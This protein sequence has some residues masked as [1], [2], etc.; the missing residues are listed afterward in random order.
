MQY[1]NPTKVPLSLAVFLAT[2]HYDHIPDTI[3]AT[4]L[5]KP[6]R[7]TV[8]SKR[9]P[10]EDAFV[11]ILGVVKSRMGT[12]IHDGIEKAWNG[13]YKTAM[14]GLGYPDK[15]IERIK[16]NPNPDDVTDNDI[17]VYMEQ[18]HFKTVR[19]VQVSGKYDF[20]AAGVL[21]DFKSTGT[22]TWVNGTKTED[23]QL[24]G[25]IYRWLSPHIITADH[26]TIQFIFTDW[27]PGRAVSPDYP[28]RA[29]EALHIPLLTLEETEAFIVNKLEQI[30]Q[31]ANASE[32][33][34]PFCNDKELWRKDPVFKYY[35]NPQKMVRSTKNFTTGPEAYARQATD[36]GKG[37]V[38]EVPGQVIA[39]K[40]C[41]AF[42]ICSQK[43]G[44]IADGSLIIE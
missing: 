23:Y 40:Y 17:P 10:R 24:Q 3:S 42:P 4:G 12:A 25:S 26:M 27:M 2:D 1:H 32:E 33:D 38:L 9:V 5:I 21:E 44:L 36:G 11:D 8:L 15:L 31:Y 39:C 35:K 13:D 34:I 22:Y 14:R 18:R 20:V 30:D 6:L 43:D 7:Q 28:Q 37:I 19:G 29:V 16:V 41:A